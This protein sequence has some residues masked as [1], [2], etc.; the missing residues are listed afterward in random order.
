MLRLAGAEDDTQ[1]TDRDACA[2]PEHC[3]V[4]EATNLRFLHRP[5]RGTATTPWHYGW[6]QTFG[7]QQSMLAG[8]SYESQQPLLYLK[9][10]ALP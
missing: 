8:R 6:N 5:L 3:Q 10:T 4:A 1:E 9:A 7:V 2:L